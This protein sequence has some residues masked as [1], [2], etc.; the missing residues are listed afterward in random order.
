MNSIHRRLHLNL[1]KEIGDKI[2]ASFYVNNIFNNRPLYRM[3]NGGNKIELASDTPI[4]FG[5]ELK[6]NI[7]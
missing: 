1:S 4:Y 7:K 5:F 3:K 6:V 2:T